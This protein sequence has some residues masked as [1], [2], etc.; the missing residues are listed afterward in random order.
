MVDPIKLKFLVGHWPEIK[1]QRTQK[2][3]WPLEYTFF[4]PESVDLDPDDIC[5]I[6]ISE[7]EY[8]T[9]EKAWR[10]YYE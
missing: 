8:D 5:I 2:E 7:H 10:Y 1:L 3:G 9:A 6:E 4:H